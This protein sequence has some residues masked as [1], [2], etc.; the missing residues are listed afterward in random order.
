M[1]V[2]KS[3]ETSLAGKAR[4]HFAKPIK[5]KW[6]RLHFWLSRSSSS[7][8]SS[9]SFCSENKRLKN[10]QILNKARTIVGV[11][12]KKKVYSTVDMFETCRV[13]FL[14]F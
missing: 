11:L 7:S 6:V 5:A 2:E 12:Q 14:A 9:T 3:K 8:S 10:E 1:F 4:Q 13:V